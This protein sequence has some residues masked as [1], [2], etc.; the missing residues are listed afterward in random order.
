MSWIISWS[1]VATELFT[2]ADFSQYPKP[3]GGSRRNL[4]AVPAPNGHYFFTAFSER[5]LSADSHQSCASYIALGWARL[6]L[7]AERPTWV[8]SVITSQPSPFGTISQVW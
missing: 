6:N 2:F 7:I 4:S 5:T 1:L 3:S 8:S